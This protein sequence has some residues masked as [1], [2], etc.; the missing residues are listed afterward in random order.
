TEG[1]MNRFVNV[2]Y[3][4]VLVC[5]QLCGCGHALNRQAARAPHYRLVSPEIAG[6]ALM[7]SFQHLPVVLEFQPGD[8]LPLELMLDSL[9]LTLV[10]TPN[11]LELVAQRQ[12]FLM[13]RENGPPVVSLDGVD[14][15]ERR[16]GYFSA[17][18]GITKSER[19]ASVRVGFWPAQPA[20]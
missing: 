4:S 9:L 5:M 15:S 20:H 6:Q 12:F 1:S 3:A 14:F 16:K 13:I 18:F 2:Y 19:K 7:D 17:G 10:P 11:R 8:K